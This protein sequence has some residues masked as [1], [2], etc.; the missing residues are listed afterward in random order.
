MSWH[1]GIDK[2]HDW[3][4][5]IFHQWTK[6][7]SR[8]IQNMVTVIPTITFEI[9]IY[10]N[11]VGRIIADIEPYVTLFHWDVPQ[12]LEDEYGG[13]LSTNIV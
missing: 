1:S 13:F 9:E 7:N 3:K 8:S 4:S 10:N 11:S 12:A 6:D 5:P 2:T